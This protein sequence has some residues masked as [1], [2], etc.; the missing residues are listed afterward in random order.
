MAQPLETTAK[1]QVRTLVL[2]TLT[3]SA[4]VVVVVVV[5]VVVRTLPTGSAAMLAMTF[6]TGNM[7]C[8]CGHRDVLLHGNVFCDCGHRDVHRL[9]TS[10]PRWWL[11]PQIFDTAV[12]GFD[13]QTETLSPFSASGWP[14]NTTCP[15]KWPWEQKTCRSPLETR[16]LLQSSITL[17]SRTNEKRGERALHGQRS[18]LLQTIRLRNTARSP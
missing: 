17:R 13:E 10:P 7:F 16:L 18:A 11:R 6:S 8:D 14:P 1:E 3:V 9:P 2:L 4:L 15:D 5:V 12:H